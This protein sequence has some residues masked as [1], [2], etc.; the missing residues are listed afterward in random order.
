MSAVPI[1]TPPQ[2]VDTFWVRLYMTGPIDDAKRVL[3]EHV[4]GM[5]ATPEIPGGCLTIE[6]TAFIYDGGEESGFVVGLI[7]YPR[8]PTTPPEL[9]EQALTIAGKLL[10]DLKQHSVLLMSPERTQWFSQRKK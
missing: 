4:Y 6:P 3:R 10:R 2:I 1:P 9:W 7:N 8:F 5:G